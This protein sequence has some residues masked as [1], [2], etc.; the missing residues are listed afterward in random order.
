VRSQWLLNAVF[1]VSTACAGDASP[2]REVQSAAAQRPAEALADD[3]AAVPADTPD[4]GPAL[5][6]AVARALLSR[7]FRAAGLRI[8]YDVP[9]AGKGYSLTV[10]GFDPV[11]AIG[12]EYIAAEERSTDL[13]PAEVAALA[14]SGDAI[15]VVAATA[16]AASIESRAAAFLAR[17]A[18]RDGGT[19]AP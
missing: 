12:F 18:T 3:V 10:D 14:A 9:R 13:K 11:R 5:D 17:H 16:D 6:E 8:R 15:L 2:R 1:L 7:M 4:A 19:Q